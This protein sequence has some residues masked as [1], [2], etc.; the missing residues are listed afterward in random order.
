MLVW[1]GEGPFDMRHLSSDFLMALYCHNLIKSK[2]LP[3]CGLTHIQ[4][5]GLSQN[6]L[7]CVK[8]QRHVL[9]LWSPDCS[10]RATIICVFT[11]R[12]VKQGILSFTYLENRL[13]RLLLTRQVCWWG[14][15]V[16]CQIWNN[17]KMWHIQHKYIF[18]A[19][20]LQISGVMAPQADA[21]FA[22]DPSYVI[23]WVSR[24]K[25]NGDKLGATTCYSKVKG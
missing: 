13:F 21:V 3:S 24:R 7:L 9:S 23:P 25:Q 14:P 22:S 19:L 12:T 11:Y 18:S 17:S 15:K 5:L 1:I 10:S 8:E 16:Q 2:I 6:K 4:C 20:C